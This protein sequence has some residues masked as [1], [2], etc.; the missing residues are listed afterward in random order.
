MKKLI[1][2]RNGLNVHNDAVD[3]TPVGEIGMK[4]MLVGAAIGTVTGLVV[5]ISSRFIG[6]RLP[7]P[8]ETTK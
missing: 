2:N 1:A 4:R 6:D 5:G 3:E 8:K 7:K